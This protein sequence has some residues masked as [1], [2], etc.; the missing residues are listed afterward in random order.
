MLHLPDPFERE[1]RNNF[2]RKITFLK[3]DGIAITK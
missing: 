3:F 1:E 2:H